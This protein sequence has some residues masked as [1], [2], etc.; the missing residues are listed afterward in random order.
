MRKIDLS[1]A[2]FLIGTIR[3]IRAEGGTFR[4]VALFPPL[5]ECLRRFHVLD[6]LDDGALHIS[7]GDADFSAVR[8]LDHGICAGCHKWVF[9]EY[10][11]LPR[12]VDA[13]PS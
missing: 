11:D 6:E 4:I 1:G 7:K 10:A 13:P 2:D 9:T 8:K 12:P 3:G 5:M